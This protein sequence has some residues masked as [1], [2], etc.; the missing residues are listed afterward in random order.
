MLTWLSLRISC[1]VVAAGILAAACGG[2]VA[3]GIPD[4]GTSGGSGTSPGKGGDVSSTA[5]TPTTTATPVPTTAPTTAPTTPT[6][7]PVPTMPPPP[8]ACNTIAVGPTV[9]AIA[10]IAADPLTPVGGAIVDG[11]YHL[12]SAVLYTGAGGGSG[13]L[14]VSIQQSISLHAGAVDTVSVSGGTTTRTSGLV[15]TNGTSQATFSQTCP[16]SKAGS[17]DEYSVS[18]SSLILFATNGAGQT[19]MYT[20]EAGP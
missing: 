14:G 2:G 6:P 16:T 19:V 1:G 9:V 10:Q 5:P 18:G 20:Y 13:P 3:T 15:T 8:G 12:T 4:D 11:T 7:T 17:T